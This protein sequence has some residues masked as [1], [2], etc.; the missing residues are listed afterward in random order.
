MTPCTLKKGIPLELSGVEWKCVLEEDT[1]Q[2]V[3][4]PGTM[5]MP[6]SYAEN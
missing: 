6:L 5:R 4:S 3:M 2:C 1:E